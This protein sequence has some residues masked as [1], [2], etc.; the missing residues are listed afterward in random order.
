MQTVILAGGM[1][2][3]LREET[4]YKPKPMIEVGG[5]PIIWHIMKNLS[6]QG[7][8][9][10]IVCLGYKGDQ[11]KDFFVNYEARANDVTVSLLSKELKVIHNDSHDE[12][13]QITLANT[14]LNT[15]TGGRILK[16]KKYTEGQRFMCTYG[17]GLADVNVSKLVS[18]HVEH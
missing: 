18:F 9:D 10:F 15:M 11:I 3:R 16:I 1:G 7:M 5:K 13:W 17:D 14:G 6:Q 4:E 2:T 12:D 8:K